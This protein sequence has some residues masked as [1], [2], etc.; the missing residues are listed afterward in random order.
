MAIL[1]VN[2]GARVAQLVRIERVHSAAV[3]RHGDGP[4][5]GVDEQA[6]G[7]ERRRRHAVTSIEQGKD[8]RYKCECR[9]SEG[10]HGCTITPRAR[11][12]LLHVGNSRLM[13]RDKA[14]I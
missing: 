5:I 7:G 10:L 6:R 13:K 12:T 3:P 8:E 4:K 9:G 1:H 14:A 2:G 11:I